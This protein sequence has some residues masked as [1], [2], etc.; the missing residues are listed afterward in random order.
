MHNY[1][2]G[3]AESINAHVDADRLGEL[4]AADQDGRCKV[5]PCHAGDM[6]WLVSRNYGTV[7]PATVTGFHLFEHGRDTLETLQVF[8]SGQAAVKRWKFSQWG[9]VIFPSE[10]EGRAALKASTK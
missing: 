7:L 2:N 10:E 4:I 8:P 6:V 5:L 1:I 3:K 9:V